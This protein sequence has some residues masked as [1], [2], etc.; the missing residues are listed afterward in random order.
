[1]IK[2][3][4][5]NHYK[6]TIQ[7]INDN[8]EIIVIVKDDLNRESI[9]TWYNTREKNSKS[10]YIN[11]CLLWW[12]LQDDIKNVLV[13]WVWWWAFI[14]YIED[15]LSNVNITWIEIDET[16]IEIAKNELYIKTDDIIIWDLVDKI[17]VLID[18]KLFYD[19]ILFDVYWWFWE[20]PE[21]VLDT[22]ILKKIKKILNKTW[23]FSINYSNF[24]IYSENMSDIKR[25]KFYKKVH[26]NIKKIIWWEYIW[27]LAWKEDWWNISWIYN[28]EKKYT[29]PKI[30]WIYFNKV[31][32]NKIKYDSKIIEW[33]Y[34]DTDCKFLD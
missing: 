30:K 19:L 7:V 11:K 29:L 3:Y 10:P 25:V 22:N 18:R 13:I 33:I 21:N 15:H 16:M 12:F 4:N 2:Y 23:I 27:F 34:L 17:E 24:A 14:K 9:Y 20:I 26:Q 1:M 28:L 32:E 5:S 6:E 8:W 31:K